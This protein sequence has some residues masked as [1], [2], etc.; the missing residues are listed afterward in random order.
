MNVAD[1]KPWEHNPRTV[2]SS[3]LQILYKTLAEYGDLSGVVFNIRNGRLVGGHMRKIFFNPNTEIVL[4]HKYDSPTAKGTTAV[5]YIPHEG[6]RFIYR[7]VDWDQDRHDAAAIAANK[8]AGKW[9]YEQLRQVIN[10]KLANLV[11][12]EATCYNKTE[13]ENLFGSWDLGKQKAASSE[14]EVESE[15]VR[16]SN[17]EERVDAFISAEQ[18][19]VIF[20]FTSEEHKKF[21][22]FNKKIL[23][24]TGLKKT[25]AAL[26][27]ILK[28]HYGE[29]SEL[30]PSV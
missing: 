24:E 5:G 2:T 21:L 4:T 15:T 7:E 23:D 17:A 25:G 27:K 16:G 3:D 12:L 13:Y 6:R 22:D 28:E 14:S 20:W 8:Q 26:L 30:T 1:L 9:N 11:D 10:D 19:Q 29:P 18:R